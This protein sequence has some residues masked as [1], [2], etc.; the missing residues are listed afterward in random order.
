MVG[1]KPSKEQNG[2]VT[3]VPYAEGPKDSLG[4]SS[5]GVLW[6]FGKGETEMGYS[7]LGN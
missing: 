1:R 7:S 4:A 5:K 3:P 2:S 6:T